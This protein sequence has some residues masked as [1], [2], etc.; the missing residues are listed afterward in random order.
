MRDPTD[1]ATDPAAH[2]RRYVKIKV[3]RFLAERGKH[4]KSPPTRQAEIILMPKIGDVPNAS[5]Q[6]EGVDIEGDAQRI[7]RRAHRLQPL[8]CIDRRLRR[9]RAQHNVVAEPAI[10]LG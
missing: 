8:D 10:G 7:W 9:G 2:N 6:V 1:V 3:R 4:T 5:H